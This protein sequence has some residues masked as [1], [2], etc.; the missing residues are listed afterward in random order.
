MNSSINY[1]LRDGQKHVGSVTADKLLEEVYPQVGIRLRGSQ[2]YY[3]QL[4][5]DLRNMMNCSGDPQFFISINLRYCPELLCH[6]RPDLYGSMDDPKWDAIEN[7]SVS[8]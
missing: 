2:A 6:C 1:A 8:C 4:K 7:V 3:D 5:S